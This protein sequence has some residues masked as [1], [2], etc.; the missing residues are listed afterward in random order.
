MRK[1]GTIKTM[2]TEIED[3]DEEDYRELFFSKKQPYYCF[4][5]EYLGSTEVINQNKKLTRVYFNK[6]FYS[7]YLTADI[8]SHLVR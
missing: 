7:K 8:K 4:F 2:S 5:K 6:P 3:E 1:D